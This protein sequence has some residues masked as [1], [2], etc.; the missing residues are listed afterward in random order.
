[1]AT[2][3]LTFVVW[4]LIVVVLGVALVSANRPPSTKDLSTH[5]HRQLIGYAG[6]VLPLALPLIAQLR[7][8]QGLDFAALDSVSSYYYTGAVAFF[9]GALVAL[10]AFLF[11]YRGY[12]NRYSLYDRIAGFVGGG[13]AI[14]VAVFPTE[15]PNLSLA[16]SWWVALTGQIHYGSAIVLFMTFACFAL[17]LFPKT[18]PDKPKPSKKNPLPRDKRLRNGFY[19]SCGVIMVACMIWAAIAKN[20]GKSIY[21]PETIALVAF[22]LSWLVKGRFEWTL[23]SIGKSTWHYTRNPGQLVNKIRH[24]KAG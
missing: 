21:W 3:G 18:D 24:P 14:G 20:N 19:I 7:P 9:T 4:P 22:A 16:P 12:D 1:M 17:F 6:L 15:A 11:T 10:A 8:T 5:S 23:A 2:D 13:A